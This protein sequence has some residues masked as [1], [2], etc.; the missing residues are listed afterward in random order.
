MKDKNLNFHCFIAGDGV[1]EDSLKAMRSSLGLQNEI[2]FLG[3]INHVSE[4]LSA[5]DVLA[6]PSNN[7]GLGTILLEGAFAGCALVGTRVGGIPEII[8]HNET[9]LIVDAG[10]AAALASE[11]SRVVCDD[12]F[13]SRLA[14]QAREHVLKNFSLEN[15]VLGNLAVYKKL[16]KPETASGEI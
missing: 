8:I 14:G 11:L 16:L 4:F 10:D 2:T 13:R 9:G 12:V 7:E 6:V 1:L 3:H 5:L 15:M